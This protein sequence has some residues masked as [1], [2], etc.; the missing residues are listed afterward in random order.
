MGKGQVAR[1]DDADFEAVSALRWYV[2]KNGY[3]ANDS[4]PRK[5]MHRM[6]MGFPDGSVDHIN[7]DRLD[8]RRA[9]LR[10]CT[11]SGNTAN[12]KL[13]RAN[14]SGYKG[15]SWDKKAGKW[16]V[17]TTKDYRHVFGGYFDSKEEAAARYAELARELHGE[18]A[19]V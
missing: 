2:A 6:V 18:F 10:V 3:A 1:V 11:Q 5:T 13:S 8:N 17:T 12:S 16:T 19:R 14:T 4:R 7:G 9:N 15:V